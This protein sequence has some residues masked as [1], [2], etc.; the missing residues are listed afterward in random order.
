MSDSTVEKQKK[1][2]F[3]VA[4]NDKAKFKV[5]LQ[6]D[7]LTQVQFF[8]EVIASYIDQ[9][10]H[11]MNFID[12][13][14]IRIKAQSKQQVNKSV[15][16]RTEAKKVSSKFALDDNELENIFDILSKEHPDL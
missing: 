10:P 3:S 1:V 5:R 7:S 8:R 6:Y 15:K 12:H 13:M 14:K 2:M 4:E 16:Q 11:F 9:D